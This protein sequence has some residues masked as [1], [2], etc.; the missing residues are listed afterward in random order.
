MNNDAS[1]MRMI[2]EG[3]LQI[4][5]YAFIFFGL[6]ALAITLWVLYRRDTLRIK[7]L[8]L[9]AWGIL[10]PVWFVVEYFFIFLPYGAPGSFGFFQYGQ[11]IASK[12]WAAVFALISIDL[13]KASERAKEAR[14]HETSEDYG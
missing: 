11:D 3:P 2:Y 6:F 5:I 9:V 8:L 1:G 14:K 10:P 7:Y 13:Y 4:G 12:L